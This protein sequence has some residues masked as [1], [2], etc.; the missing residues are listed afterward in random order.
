[1]YS[2]PGVPLRMPAICSSV[3][4]QPSPSFAD[5]RG[6]FVRDDRRL[7]AVDVTTDRSLWEFGGDGELI[8]VEG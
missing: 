1:M 6:F 2:S 8:A 7:E 3:H 4:S 5:G